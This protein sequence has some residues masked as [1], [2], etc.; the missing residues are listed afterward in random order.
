MVSP[1]CVELTIQGGHC[2]PY[3]YPKALS[4]IEKNQLP[5]E[6]SDY[7]DY[8]KPELYTVVMS[9]RCIEE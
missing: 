6:V 8:S 4:M 7:V 1:S 2:S 5:L 3:C 9:I